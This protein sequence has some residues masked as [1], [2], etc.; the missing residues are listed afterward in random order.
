MRVY[1]LIRGKRTGDWLVSLG[2][3]PCLYG[4]DSWKPAGTPA[5]ERGFDWVQE[6]APPDKNR[7][8]VNIRPDRILPSRP[9]WFTD[10]D[11]RRVVAAA[12]LR[13]WRAERR[14]TQQI[15][16]AARRPQPSL[17]RGDS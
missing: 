8:W 6:G 7:P 13:A 17:V 5:N 10:L 4:P 2:R 14:A 12:E 11:A 15:R 16:L 1:Y 9:V 3:V